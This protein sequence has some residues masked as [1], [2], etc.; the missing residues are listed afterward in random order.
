MGE[1]PELTERG[2]LNA[3]FTSGDPGSVASDQPSTI[4]LK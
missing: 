4:M 2:G 3:Y 1:I